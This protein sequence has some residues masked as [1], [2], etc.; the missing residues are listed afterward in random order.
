M[1][2]WIK[3]LPIP[4]I[5]ISI[6]AGF[7]FFNTEKSGKESV[8]PILFSHKVHAGDNQIACLNCHGSF[9]EY[10]E[11]IVVNPGMP[12]LE[13]C[14]SCHEQI[15]GRDIEYDFNGTKINIRNEISKLRQYREE[16]EEIPWIKLSSTADHLHFYHK[17]HVKSGRECKECH[18][19][20]EE[21]DQV[22]EI[23][24][25]DDRFC[26]SCHEKYVVNHDGL[27][28]IN[29]CI[30]CRCLFNNYRVCLLLARSYHFVKSI[31]PF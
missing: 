1:K 7:Y 6:L 8:Q 22:R 11:K 16:N 20:V 4:I 18:G 24:N 29:N 25:L 30:T 17:A 26:I 13:T 21:M 2:K 27:T 14:I 19:D 15:A 5:L 9:L 23:R 31:L 28:H 12:S 3:L 10:P